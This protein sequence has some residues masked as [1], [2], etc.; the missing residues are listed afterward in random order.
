MCVLLFALTVVF[1]LAASYGAKML[2]DALLVGRLPILGSFAGL[3]YAHNPGIAFSVDLG[4]YQDA[5]ILG[6]LALICVVAWKSA[7]TM[8]SRIGF[9][10]IIGGALGNV[11]D[12]IPDGVVTDF[13]QVSTFPIFNVADSCITVGVVILLLE[14]VL[15]RKSAASADR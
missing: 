14:S 1:S 12:R 9:G 13:F 15:R 10:L 7:K 4:N 3:Q 6:A 11:I 8:T 5:V 2:A